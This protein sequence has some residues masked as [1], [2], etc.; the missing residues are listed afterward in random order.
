[1]RGSAATTASQSVNNSSIHGLKGRVAVVT[2]GSRGIGRAIALALASAGAAVGVTYRERAD[3]ARQVVE[4]SADAGGTA[5]AEP[6]DVSN[7]ADVAGAFARVAAALGTVDILVN[8]AG[9]VEDAL[10]LFTDRA[11]WDRVMGTNLDGA[12][13]CT[14][15]VVRGMLLRKWGRIVNITSLSAQAGLAGQS[16]YAAS[17]AGL[18]GLTRALAQEL[19]RHG[20][21]VNAVAPGLVDTEMLAAMPAPR[22]EQLAAASALGRVG[23]PEEVGALV[24]FLASN[25]ASYITGQTIAVDGGL[26]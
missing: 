23:T 8:N 1:V 19:G 25:A 16:G 5:V 7:E 26:L 15:A 11:K 21:L 3:D 9:I 24:A 17:K 14:R 4:T 12:Y 22:R 18:V 6:C 20:V 13:F 2:G 10:F